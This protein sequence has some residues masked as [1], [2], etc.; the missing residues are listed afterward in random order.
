MAGVLYLVSLPI[1][2][3]GDVTLRAIETLKA[4]D[5]IVAEDTRN[6]RRVLERY[7]IETPFFSSLYQGAERRRVEKILDALREGR[8]L[9]LVSDAGTPLVSDPGYPLVRRAID[10][11]LRVVPI[12]G[13][14]AAIAAL[15]GSGLPSDR[16][17]F[18]GNVPRKAEAR[19]TLFDRLAHE[20]RTTILYE[21]PHRLLATLRAAA[22][23]LPVRQVVLAR[24]LTKVHEE[25]LRGSPGEILSILEDR[26][27]VKGECVLLVAGRAVPEQVF[28]RRAAERMRDLLKEEGI[29]N[30][31]VVGILKEVLGVPRN[32]AYAL[33]Q[34]WASQQPS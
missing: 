33:V 9:A 25:F 24:E 19:R 6:T 17:S 31:V 15:V 27:S 13:P 10:L 30:R 7:S 29:S 5:A 23:A 18:E 22:D 2:N 16:F 1:G 34:G 32:E 26:E 11:G 21:S 8:S 4:V 14:T 12:P 20:D 3:L 28:D